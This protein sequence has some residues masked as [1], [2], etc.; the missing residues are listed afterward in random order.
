[1]QGKEKAHSIHTSDPLIWF[2][3][4][5]EQPNLTQSAFLTQ[6]F[7]T[8]SPGRWWSHHPRGCLRK[9]WMWGHG[10][11]GGIGNMLLPSPASCSSQTSGK[12]TSALFLKGTTR[13]IKRKST[14]S[15]TLHLL[16]GDPGTRGGGMQLFQFSE[17]YESTEKHLLKLTLVLGGIFL[18]SCNCLLENKLLPSGT[19]L[20]N[21]S[22]TVS[23]QPSWC[24]STSVPCFH[25][26]HLS[27]VFR[28]IKKFNHS[29]ENSPLETG[30]GLQRVPIRGAAWICHQI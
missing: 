30:A 28:D 9:G 23:L 11:V 7:H 25:F 8:P 16:L 6:A 26:P 27:L 2:S 22:L 18:N 21:C 29:R 10:L 15:E 5:L 13:D 14:L 19:L 17:C 1:M 24:G 3:R 4:A 20:S 12:K